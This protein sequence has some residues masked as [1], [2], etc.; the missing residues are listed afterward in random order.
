MENIKKI[1]SKQLTVKTAEELT[2]FDLI[3]VKI[4]KMLMG[5]TGDCIVTLNTELKQI[6]YPLNNMESTMLTYIQSGCH[7]NTLINTIYDIYL[8]TMTGL[9]NKLE[10]G[11]IE[12][13][14]G[15]IFYGRLKWVNKKGE[16]FFIKCTAGDAI[17][18]A[19]LAKADVYI[20][21]KVVDETEAFEMTYQDDIYMN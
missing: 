13:K 11:V 9:Q 4:D 2:E 7:E 12:S 1:K 3:P 16:N 15:D 8:S 21:R 17:I 14:V 6:A 18:L 5:P 10:A 20:I 19:V